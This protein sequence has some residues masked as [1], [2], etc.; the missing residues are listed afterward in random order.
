MLFHCPQ[1]ARSRTDQVSPGNYVPE[2]LNSA[3][4]AVPL[5]RGRQGFELL[6]QIP[7]ADSGLVSQDSEKDKNQ[8]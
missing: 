5:Q 4:A 8:A 2:P 3:G 6:S 7:L 1:L